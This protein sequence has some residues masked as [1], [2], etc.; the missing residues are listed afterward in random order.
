MHVEQQQQQQQQQHSPWAPSGYLRGGGGPSVQ[1]GR[2]PQS[3][4][5]QPLPTAPEH[6]CGA[7]AAAAAAAAQPLGT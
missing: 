3:I 4:R 1:N 2:P 5:A 6:A 7:A